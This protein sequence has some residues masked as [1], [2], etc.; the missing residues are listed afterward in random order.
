MP[1]TQLSAADV[2]A[3]TTFLVGSLDSPSQAAFRTIPSTFRYEPKGSQKDLQD[4]WWIVKKYNCMGCHNI[5]VG[6]K[7]SLSASPRY[8]D[9]DWK[10]KLPPALL[11][12]GARV[13][14]DWLARFL[15]NPSLNDKDASRNGVRTY[16]QVRMPTFNL[17]PNEIRVLVRFFDAMAGQAFPYI[18]Q[19]LEALDEREWQMA[20]TLFSSRGAVCLKCHLIGEPQHDRLATAPNFLIAAERLKPDWTARWMIEPQ[21]ISPGTA[22]PSGLFHQEGGR[23]VFAGETPDRFRGYTKDHVQLLVRYMFQFTPEE[24]RR[25][26]RMLPVT[27]SAI[28]M[29]AGRSPIQ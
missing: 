11:E 8:Q 6:Q 18:P 9:P 22:M 5:Q 12:E 3:L 16:L 14:P 23:W 24:Q 1:D 10:E 25:L 20:R 2:R 26:I 15:A 27:E 28:G 7:S 21:N 13:N 29:P 17:S 19:R 4:G